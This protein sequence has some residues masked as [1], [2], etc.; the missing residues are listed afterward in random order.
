MHIDTPF[1]AREEREETY[2]LSPAYRRLFDRVLHYSRETVIDPA[3]GQR[4]QRV[5]WW[6]V[7]ALLRAMGSS[8]AAAA[9]TLR[10]R[11]PTADAETAEDVDELG[12][13]FV[14]DVASEDQAESMD[15]VPGSDSSEERAG[16]GG[17]RRRLLEMAR[18]VGGTGGKPPISK[19]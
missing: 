13:R 14:L 19:R 17:E 7:L 8:P 12:R 16:A 2:I 3:G 4:R 15:V 10:N 5:R 9:A 6:S 18:E 1:P 11:T